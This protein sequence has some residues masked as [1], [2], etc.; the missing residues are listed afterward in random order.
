MS[1]AFRWDTS[2]GTAALPVEGISECPRALL[3]PIHADV[4]SMQFIDVILCDGVPENGYKCRFVVEWAGGHTLTLPISRLEPFGSP[5]PLG[6]Q[7]E[8]RLECRSSG[9]AEAVLEIE[10]PR[11]SESMPLV[12]INE[13]EC[14]LETFTAPG[15]WEAREWTLT[16]GQGSF[17]K[18][19]VYAR[20]SADAGAGR[21]GKVAYTKRYDADIKSYQAVIIGL[22][23]DETGAFSLWATVD[24]VR[25]LVVD[26]KQGS[27]FEELRIPVSGDVLNELTLQ[28]EGAAPGHTGASDVTPISLI[29]W[30]MLESAGEQ[31]AIAN[32]VFGREKW[33]DPVERCAEAAIAAGDGVHPEALPVGFLFDREALSMLKKRIGRAGSRH[34]R[35]M[36]EIREEAEANLDY[37]PE[38]YWGTYMPVNWARQGIERASS[39]N[40]E[41]HR[42]FSTLVYSAFAYAVDGDARFGNA[43]R[44]ALLTVI[45][46][47][48]WAAGF[49]AR[50]PIGLRG[51]RAPFIESHTAQA[52]ALCYDFI[53]PL[54]SEP[55]RRETEDALYDK[56]VLWLDAF[57]R[58]NGKGYL[59]ASNQG[60]VYALGLL[61]AAHAAKRSRPEAA[62]A[63]SRWGRWLEEMLAGYYQPD[64][65]TNEGMMYWE[66]TTNHAIEALLLISR[67]EGRAI[68]DLIP[69]SMAETINYVLHL[70]S[71]ATP[72]L[73]FLTVGDCR[74][75]DFHYMGPPLLFFHHYLGDSRALALWNEHYDIAHPP[76]SPFFGSVIGT[77]QYTTNG[78]LTLLLLQGEEAKA[79]ELPEQQLFDST[80]RLFWRT[81]GEF[82]DKLFFFEG[83]A[84]SFEHTHF[85]KG[86]FIIEAYGESL[87]TDPG[88]IV[89]SRPFST[90]L[91]AT[92]FHNVIT[93]NGKD[94]SYRD[95]SRA[96]LFRELSEGE[97]YR[98]MDADL[99]D[100]YKELA[101]CRRRI[102]FVKPDYWLVMDEADSTEPGLEWNL[103]SK[104]LFHVLKE[105]EEVLCFR[106]QARLA[107]MAAAI[108]ADTPLSPRFAS[109]TDEG[110]TLSHHVS[111]HTGRDVSRF[112]LAA[113]LVPY[114]G[115]LGDGEA[116]VT[117]TAVRTAAGAEFVVSGDFGTDRVF[118]NF[119]DN[120]VLV[121]RGDGAIITCGGSA[122]AGQ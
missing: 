14:L 38:A 63:A 71:L 10:T 60:A 92:R 101:V 98:Y 31:P 105:G 96:V 108:V 47:R 33:S 62:K 15:F 90:L 86:Q 119:H 49:V 97:G 68:E 69:P 7:S 19:W 121:Q 18:K 114:K 1:I 64:G 59:L 55:E 40:E 9:L 111:L 35:L 26:R 95:A 103:H 106:A 54:L 11:W 61:Y 30:I 93:V 80:Q 58:Q 87:A 41:T 74:N 102:L 5:G 82:G 25:E 79:C 76:G 27:G 81:G 39:P 122:G 37:D 8:L 22:S 117:S 23:T 16:A 34:A 50:Y 53:Y 77:G 72:S 67:L 100:S 24:G 94:Q 104:G 107:G 48:H 65:S 36:Q 21:P 78:L 110:E 51:Y 52:V 43:A 115:T 88:M 3:L 118:C 56:G 120:S 4:A 75:E 109:Y 17:E 45:R 44:R 46:L 112:K 116:A 70:R 6:T 73:R 12:A 91:K 99:T 32:E 29:Y 20:L 85:D 57:L 42:L 2:K 66:Y 13:R 84:Q 113:L 83:G 28:L 89:Y